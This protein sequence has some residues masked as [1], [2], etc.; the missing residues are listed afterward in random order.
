MSPVAPPGCPLGTDVEWPILGGPFPLPER[1]AF[2]RC[3][4]VRKAQ[5][6]ARA[7]VQPCVE[8]GAPGAGPSPF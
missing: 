1:K 7:S 2:L 5:G 3:F 8:N 4:P 6:G